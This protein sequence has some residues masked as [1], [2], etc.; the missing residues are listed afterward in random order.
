MDAITF[1]GIIVSIDFVLYRSLFNFKRKGYQVKR[2]THTRTKLK[3]IYNA[4]LRV[5]FEA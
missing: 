2:Y 5:I 4:S 3:A 1:N